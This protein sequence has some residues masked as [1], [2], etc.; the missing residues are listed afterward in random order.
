MAEHLTHGWEPDLDVGDSLLRRF[1]HAV[2]DRVAFM[3][4]VAGGSV[5]RADDVVLGDA[6]SPAP[7]DNGAVL[8][9]PPEICDVHD[10]VHRLDAAVPRSRGFVLLSAWPLSDLSVQ[11]LELM[12][13]PPLMFRPA[14]GTAPSGPPELEIV[15]A[16]G[17]H[18]RAVFARALTE[19]YPMPGGD[20]GPFGRDEILDG[21][22]R[23]YVG[24]VDGLPV[25]TAG[26]CVAHGLIDV[27]WVST[28]PGARRRGYGEALT[29]AAT[30]ADPSLPAALIASDLG[31]AIY[32]RMGYVRLLRM[33]L[34]WRPPSG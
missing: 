30:V 27:E 25:A 2:A 17:H 13:H 28:M 8:L 14:G 24:L 4:E 5:M 12:G 11:G 22:L 3:A 29:W 33:S 34:W 26:A 9:Q 6:G 18:E 16:R 19:G 32:E 10:V 31:Q 21:P 15:E 1:V 23:L 7:Y 20:E